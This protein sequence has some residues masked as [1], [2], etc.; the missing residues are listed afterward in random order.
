MCCD[1]HITRLIN[2]FAGFDD[3]FAPEKSIGEKTQELFAALA[4]KECSLLEK[5]AEG[6]RGLRKFGVPEEEWEPPAFPLGLPAVLTPCEAG[7]WALN[8]LPEA[9]GGVSGA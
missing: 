7:W 9:G 1:G 4:A 3:A 2:V 8:G 5:V 6:V